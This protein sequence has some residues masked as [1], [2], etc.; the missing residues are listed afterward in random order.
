[1]HTCV[2][3][4]PESHERRHIDFVKALQNAQLLLVEWTG[5]ELRAG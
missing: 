5:R 2:P 4:P 3:Q 1:M